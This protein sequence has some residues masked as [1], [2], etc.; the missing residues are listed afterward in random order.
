MQ[1]SD[2]P[3][4]VTLSAHISALVA[5]HSTLQHSGGAVLF[6]LLISV[7]ELQT[8]AARRIKFPRRLI[9]TYSRGVW[10]FP[11]SKCLGEGGSQR[12]TF[13]CGLIVEICEQPW[14]GRV[15]RDKRNIWMGTIQMDNSN[16][17]QHRNSAHAVA[18]LPTFRLQSNDRC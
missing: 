1:F 11:F 6:V 8:R 4:S 14:N 12:G 2:S 18:K 16:G 10:G 15:K 5:G 3:Y 7:T 17:K 13:S 9:Q